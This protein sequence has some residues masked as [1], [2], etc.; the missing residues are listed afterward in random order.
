MDDNQFGLQKKPKLYFVLV[1]GE[2]ENDPK[3]CVS[4]V[5][6]FFKTE[7][8]KVGEYKEYSFLKYFQT[9]EPEDEIDVELS[10]I[11]FKWETTDEGGDSANQPAN[12]RLT[13]L[14]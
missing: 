11:L 6:L 8:W 12:L 9:G 10:C 13:V 7:E 3:I 14:S 1:R 5:L 2:R 4:K